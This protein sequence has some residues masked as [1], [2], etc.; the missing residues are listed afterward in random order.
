MTPGEE[1]DHSYDMFDE[2]RWRCVAH[3][4]DVFDAPIESFDR[5]AGKCDAQAKSSFEPKGQAYDLNMALVETNVGMMEAAGTLDEHKEKEYVCTT[6]VQSAYFNSDNPY[7][8][9]FSI[10]MHPNARVYY[11]GT[12]EGEE[13]EEAK[14][15][16]WNTESWGVS[17]EYIPEL[18]TS[19]CS[20]PLCESGATGEAQ[21]RHSPVEP[22]LG[23]VDTAVPLFSDEFPGLL[24]ISM[25][26]SSWMTV[27]KGLGRSLDQLS[28]AKASK[29]ESAGGSYW[30]KAWHHSYDKR[31]VP[32]DFTEEMDPR[33][34]YVYLPSENILVFE[35]GA[36][37]WQCV[38]HPG[39]T[40]RIHKINDS[41]YEVVR[42]DGYREVYK[43]S[44]LSRIEYPDGGVITLEKGM[45]DNSLATTITDNRSSAGVVVKESFT[46]QIKQI[47]SLNDPDYAFD[48]EYTDIGR[49]LKKMLTG[50]RRPDGSRIAI[51][52]T[53]IE[54]SSP[55]H[56][57]FLLNDIS[58]AG[59]NLLSIDYDTQG[60]ATSLEYASGETYQIS[61]SG[62]STTR[63]DASTGPDVTLTSSRV[64]TTNSNFHGDIET[65]RVTSAQCTD[66]DFHET[67]T[68]TADG[69]LQ[70][71]QRGGSRSYSASYGTHAL[72]DRIDNDGADDYEFDWDY[73]RRQLQHISGGQVLP[74]SLSH[75]KN[76]RVDG[77]TSSGASES[78]KI[79]M[80][81]ADGRVTELET[82][83]NNRISVDYT[84]EGYISQIQNSLGHDYQFR[85]HNHLGQPQT[86]V[87][88][89]GVETA[90][91]YDKMGR[92]TSSTHNGE[93]LLDFQYNQL[94]Q[95]TEASLRGRS[96]KLHYDTR[97]RLSRVENECGQGTRFD[98]NPNGRLAR[99]SDTGSTT[100][101]A[102][103][104]RYDAEGYQTGVSGQ[105]GEYAYEAVFDD[106]G[107][108][109]RETHGDNHT[110]Y[111]YDE[112]GVMVGSTTN[113]GPAAVFAPG[114]LG[115]IEG[116]SSPGTRQT[117]LSYTELGQLRSQQNSN[118]GTRE[119][120]YASASGLLNER[121]TERSRSVYDYD[122]GDR[123]TAITHTDQ[124]NERTPVSVTYQYDETKRPNGERNYGVGR[125]TG[126][127][128]N[129]ARYDFSYDASGTLT[130]QKVAFEEGG[131]HLSGTVQYHHNDHG[132]RVTTEY[133]G[134]D[135]LT[136]ERDRC[137][138][139]VTAIHW[140]GQKLADLEPDR[141]LPTYTGA[142]LSNGL[143]VD[144]AFDGRGRLTELNVDAS[145]VLEQVYEYDGAGNLA[146]VRSHSAIDALDGTWDFDYD[147]LNRLT[148]ADTPRKVM[149]Y[150]YD[151]QGRRASRTDA[152]ESVDYDYGEDNDRLRQRLDQS[153]QPLAHY[154]Y[155]ADG[156]RVRADEWEY[157][158]NAA[159]RLTEVYKAG[160]WVASYRYDAKGKR[161]SKETAD[162]T[163]YFY[164][165]D[166]G[167]LLQE[168]RA[169]GTVVRQYLY[170]PQGELF[171]MVDANDELYFV[172]L[173]HLGAP[174][175][176]TD[177]AGD[178]A[179]SARR[180]PFGET[181]VI[182]SE[183]TFPVRL[184]GQYHDPETGLHYNQQRYYDPA[185]GTYL[186]PDPLGLAGGYHAYA[187]TNHNPTSYVDPEGEILF[188]AALQ[189]LSTG[190]AA[191][192]LAK[193]A[194]HIVDGVAGSKPGFEDLAAG[195]AKAQA[196]RLASQATP[197]LDRTQDMLSAAGLVPGAGIA[198]DAANTVISLGNL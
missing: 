159:G 143:S 26:Y 50:I 87:D 136:Y 157:Q 34:I 112:Q 149:A 161:I 7:T 178:V 113:E 184:P 42:E 150:E 75:N 89:N 57:L 53:P 110:A 193:A 126:L 40:S 170:T 4:S 148:R 28:R 121:T 139:E 123:L 93:P 191:M 59:Q 138:G 146:G 171:A 37:G 129:A 132:E 133:P 175:M 180:T 117:T 8:G 145:D 183:V 140:N 195:F 35:K 85:D 198:P 128:S 120:D 29:E 80:T 160:Q 144:R 39:V 86:V 185:T 108:I 65:T 20:D 30:Q 17:L 55:T 91:D 94:G 197:G 73:G 99:I 98:Y 18:Q 15:V 166:D 158:Y 43:Q 84:A 58:L 168:R 25:H 104:Y 181:E 116:V 83:H 96:L 92:L 162:G 27:S 41:T 44:E 66:C 105:F 189:V 81:R 173:D 38:S 135:K 156:N 119:Y 137:S 172:H 151:Q 52:Q 179:W 167:R 3:P 14:L 21:Y 97:N 115:R 90:L 31:L 46:G 72:L 23:T 118:W 194:D 16:P 48:F 154:D 124:K 1:P 134:G 131:Q 125:L 155:D 74:T 63:V 102:I 82:P 9:R 33:R 19:Q 174:V 45:V 177:E 56:G 114:E 176:L 152:G 165:N 182:Q 88:P 142:N 22:G 164:H 130:H 190:G 196:R 12:I 100:E 2:R 36:N 109:T 51:N 192:N 62:R 32:A 79:S 169:D 187:Y 49:P 95:P 111:S 147:N 64:A 77:A 67:Y 68:Y 106:R 163:L 107:R 61:Y 103:R 5:A 13:I 60:R 188:P 153:G 186:R 11:S 69:V 127:A 70:S 54:T 24:P 101:T 6:G 76:N 78:R 141:R 71:E 122:A 10:A 47:H